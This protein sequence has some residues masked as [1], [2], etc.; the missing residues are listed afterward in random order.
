VARLPREE[1]ILALGVGIFSSPAAVFSF[2]SSASAAQVVFQVFLAGI[3]LQ[4]RSDGTARGGGWGGLHM[5]VLLERRMEPVSFRIFRKSPNAKQSMNLKLSSLTYCAAA[6]TTAVARRSRRPRSAGAI[7]ETY[8]SPNGGAPWAWPSAHRKPAAIGR[9]TFLDPQAQHIP[10]M[11]SSPSGNGS[12]VLRQSHHAERAQTMTRQFR[13]G[14][15]IESPS[16]S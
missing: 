6:L 14:H 8:S 12:D 5:G 13:R 11:V 16:S 10:T 15:R 1:G 2:P 9:S 3:T 7:G 4:S